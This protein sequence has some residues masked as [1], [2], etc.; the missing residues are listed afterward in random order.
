MGFTNSSL[1]DYKKISPNK[2]S[3]EGHK[4]DTISI[5]CVVGQCSV[6]TLGAYLPILLNKH[7]LTME[8]V[9]MEKS[10]CM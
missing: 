4:I 3:R 9:T 1:V 7:R 5:H 2:S 6:E 8:L 10:E